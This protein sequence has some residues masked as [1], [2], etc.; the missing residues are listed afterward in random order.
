MDELGTNFLARSTTSRSNQNQPHRVMKGD[1]FK[2]KRASA[3]QASD[4]P[5]SIPLDVDS[6]KHF[7]RDNPPMCGICPDPLRPRNGC[8]PALIIYAL[9]KSRLLQRFSEAFG[10]PSPDGLGDCYEISVALLSDIAE[11]G[12]AFGWRGVDGFGKFGGPEKGLFQHAWLEN[13]GWAIDAANGGMLIIDAALY[14][15]MVG[16]KKITRKKPRQILRLYDRMARKIRGGRK[17]S[18]SPRWFD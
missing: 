13:D 9:S 18:L 8:N 3:A 1:A 4:P 15:R 11:A 6:L 14:Y 12:Q 16:A 7:S 5:G 17:N 2:R 10:R